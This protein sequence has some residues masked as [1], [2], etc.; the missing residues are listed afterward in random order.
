VLDF[1]LSKEGKKVD[2][3]YCSS[4]LK[5]KNKDTGKVVLTANKLIK[6]FKCKECLDKMVKPK[7]IYV[8]RTY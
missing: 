4:C 3:R 8:P 6:R 1:H 2:K 5:F 7:E